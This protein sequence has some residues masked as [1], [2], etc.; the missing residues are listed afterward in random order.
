ML[1]LEWIHVVM[2]Y[3]NCIIITFQFNKIPATQSSPA[4]FSIDTHKKGA[5]SSMACF[6]PLP[7]DCYVCLTQMNYIQPIYRA[8]LTDTVLLSFHN[9][10]IHIS[11]P[12]VAILLMQ[13]YLMAS[14][15]PPIMLY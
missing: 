3:I 11:F 5:D 12:N 1:S 8:I 7:K 6:E 13:T 10:V 4:P 14:Y 9:S 15:L 2:D